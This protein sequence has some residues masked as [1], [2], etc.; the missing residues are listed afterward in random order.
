MWQCS[1]SKLGF[2]G[3]KWQ[4]KIYNIIFLRA[5]G[6]RWHW[7]LRDS[8]GFDSVVGSRALYGWQHRGLRE[9]NDVAGPETM[10][11][12]GVVGSRTTLRAHRRGLREDNVV[13]GSRTVSWAWGR[14]LCGRRR[15]RLGSGKMTSHRG[16]RPWMGNTARRLRGELDDG[17]EASG[18]SRQWHRFRGSQ[19]WY[20]LHGN[21]CYKI[22][23]PD[24]V[25]ES[26]RGLWFA[27]VAQRFIYWRITIAMSTSDV[28]IFVAS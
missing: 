25:S 15:L 27:K 13:V 9:D 26:I 7:G 5:W 18:K 11:V 4:R 24:C 12:D 22:W 2:M 20:R 14:C 16:A 6:G 10:R 21:F 1:I 3:P 23:Q 19:R 8:V 17:A 28:S